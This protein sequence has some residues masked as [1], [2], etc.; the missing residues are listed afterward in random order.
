[1]PRTDEETGKVITAVA[2]ES[3]PAVLLD[4]ASTM[5]GCSALDAALTSDTWNDRILGKSETTGELPWRTVLIATGND[6]SFAADTARRVVLCSLKC[7]HEAP[8]D[9]TGFKH[10]NVDQFA[11]DERAR[12][13]VAALTILRAFVVA[14]KPYR[15][16][17][18][19]SFESWS[20]TICGA[21]VFAGLSNPLET[22]SVV[23]EQD[24]SGAIFRGL[25]DGLAEV[26]D[27]DGLTSKQIHDGIRSI[28]GDNPKPEFTTL[29][30][31]F[32]GITDK[33][34]G[35][36]IGNEFRKYLER[37]SDGRRIV[38]AGKRAGVVRWTVEQV[39]NAVDVEDGDVGDVGDCENCGQPLTATPTT[40]GRYLNRYCET[41][42][43]DHTCIEAP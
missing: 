35:R 15:G 2:I 38:K 29:R 34:T 22:V 12:L 13:V 43:T 11:K 33:L 1:M 40:C 41:C 28:D 26:A 20:E 32:G 3:K 16:N 4:N 37:V 5:V 19:G 39:A 17:R 6:L 27:K 18:L 21:I 30:D 23:R 7:D 31:V 10:S 24:N 25:L 36:K 9:R 8:E 14:G 42:D